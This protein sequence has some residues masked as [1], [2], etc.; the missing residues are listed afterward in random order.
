MQHEQKWQTFTGYGII[1]S[2]MYDGNFPTD[3]ISPLCNII[4]KT[5]H[6]EIPKGNLLSW[7][8]LVRCNRICRGYPWKWNVAEKH[9]SECRYK[10]HR[11]LHG[12]QTNVSVRNQN[13]QVRKIAVITLDINQ[14]ITFITD[15]SD[16]AAI[17]TP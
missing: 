1:D 16:L 9:E 12:N 3:F 13:K 17:A 2:T 14:T 5:L 10:L 8:P 4:E 7:S 6:T 11:N 15:D